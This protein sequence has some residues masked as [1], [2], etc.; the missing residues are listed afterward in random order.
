MPKDSGQSARTK[1]KTTSPDEVPRELLAL[2]AEVA[3]NSQKKTKRPA[4][5]SGKKPGS[6]SQSPASTEAVPFAHRSPLWNLYAYNIMNAPIEDG[7]WV[8]DRYDYDDGHYG[9]YEEELYPQPQADMYY[10][11]PVR[12]GPVPGPMMT[13]SAPTETTGTD[14]NAL[15]SGATAADALLPSENTGGE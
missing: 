10:E 13:A 7:E 3:G 9:Q 2:A 5:S 6:Q 15:I 4:A 12:Y 11:P 8:D 14:E 1:P